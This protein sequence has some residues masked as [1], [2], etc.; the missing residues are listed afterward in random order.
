L[1]ISSSNEGVLDTI[2]I[3][4][5]RVIPGD[6]VDENGNDRRSKGRIGERG[7]PFDNDKDNHIPKSAK[8]K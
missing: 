4:I 6:E 3:I 7:Q 1:E 5:Y 2:I 8:E